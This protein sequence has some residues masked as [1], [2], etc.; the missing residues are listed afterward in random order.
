MTT[1]SQYDSLMTHRFRA[2]FTAALAFSPLLCLSAETAFEQ[3]CA[4]IASRAGNDS[5]RLHDLFKLDWEHAMV[6]HPEF[7]TAVGYPGQNDRWTDQS[8]EAVERRKGELQAP[9]K[10]IQSIDRSK[11]SAADQ[12]NYDLF[13]KN[14]EDA[15]EGS[16]FKNEYMPLTQLN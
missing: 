6:E 13:K 1:K 14:H 7:A 12:L 16:R 15:I 3:N 2:F 8:L 5:E 10:V 11:L 9:L 4:Q